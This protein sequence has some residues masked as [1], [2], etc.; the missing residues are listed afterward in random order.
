MDA[1]A[2]RLAASSSAS[3]VNMSEARGPTAW[4]SWSET[5][6]VDSHLRAAAGD[7]LDYEDRRAVA[8]AEDTVWFPGGNN[9]VPDGKDSE[10]TSVLRR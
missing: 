3:V 9:N 5:G 6:I 8:G 7:D 2:P 1:G 4:V 10:A